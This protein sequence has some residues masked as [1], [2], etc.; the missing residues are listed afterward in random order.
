MNR[1]QRDKENI[2]VVLSRPQIGAMAEDKAAVV[3][4]MRKRTLY[5]LP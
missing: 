1:Y 2:Q 4:E 5:C 3:V